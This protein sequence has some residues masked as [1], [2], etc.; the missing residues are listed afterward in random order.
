MKPPQLLSAY[1]NTDIKVSLSKDTEK[2]VLGTEVQSWDL[3]DS[4]APPR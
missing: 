4:N 3:Y 2:T 1:G